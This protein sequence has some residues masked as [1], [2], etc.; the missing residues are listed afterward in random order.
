MCH[1]RHHIYLLFPSLG[2]MSRVLIALHL[3]I[4]HDDDITR[5]LANCDEKYKFFVYP[6]SILQ[7][8]TVDS[9]VIVTSHFEITR[10]LHAWCTCPNR[11]LKMSTSITNEL[12]IP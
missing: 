10:K 4:A 11:V 1:P 6:Y 2:V 7:E 12:D 3:P 9:E 5:Q 8:F